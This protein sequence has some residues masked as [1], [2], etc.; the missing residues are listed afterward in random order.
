MTPILN[1]FDCSE[2]PLHDASIRAT[3]SAPTSSHT[4]RRFIAV[5][6]W[7]RVLALQFPRGN[8]NV[9]R[10]G[11]VAS[12][13]G[14]AGDWGIREVGGRSQYAEPEGQP[15]TDTVRKRLAWI[16]NSTSVCRLC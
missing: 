6:S 13:G 8:R 4:A 5:L 1:V 7:A 16:G 12:R 3:G 11:R 2:P 9:A 15:Q 10:E 14:E